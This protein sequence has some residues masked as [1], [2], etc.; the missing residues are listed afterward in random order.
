MRCTRCRKEIHI[1]R[2][3]WQIA[4]GVCGSDRFIELEAELF[5]SRECF[6][7]HVGS[8]DKPE[9]E[10]APEYGGG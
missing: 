1:G 2:D 7:H 9:P 5:C 3:C 6:E 10:F 4:R 8:E